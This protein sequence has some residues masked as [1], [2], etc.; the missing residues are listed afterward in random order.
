[1]PKTTAEWENSYLWAVM[2]DGKDAEKGPHVYDWDHEFFYKVAKS[3]SDIYAKEGTPEGEEDLTLDLVEKIRKG[4]F[5]GHAHYDPP[6]YKG[7]GGIM[8]HCTDRMKCPDR[9]SLLERIPEYLYTFKNGTEDCPTHLRPHVD[10][11]KPDLL[12]RIIASYNEDLA[13]AR[14]NGGKKNDMLNAIVAF[15]RSFAFLHPFQNGNGR[16]RNLLLQ[17]EIRRLKVGCGTIMYNNNK[18]AFVDGWPRYRAKVL[19]GIQMFE[20]GYAK[21]ANP[22]LNQTKQ[23]MHLKHFETLH[24]LSECSEKDMGSGGSIAL[25]REEDQQ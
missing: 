9:L 25:H 10:G 24:G 14:E 7:G 1:M 20:E 23:E 2:I 16:L 13:S 4:A 11:D 17:R 18:D 6:Y 19:E 15:A 12:Q 8:P 3:L 5:D 22:W 21:K